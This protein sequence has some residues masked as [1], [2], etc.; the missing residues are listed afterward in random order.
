LLGG[1]DAAIFVRAAIL[2]G[3]GL[4]LWVVNRLVVGKPERVDAEKLQA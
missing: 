1:N 3:I 4:A 2:V